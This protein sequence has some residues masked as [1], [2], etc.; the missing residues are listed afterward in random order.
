MQVSGS[1]QTVSAAGIG[2]I[3]SVSWA[4]PENQNKTN[5]DYYN[6]TLI[7]SH[8]NYTVTLDRLTSLQTYLYSFGVSEANYSAVS[9][10]AVD[11]CGQTS[12]SLLNLTSSVE[13]LSTLCT[14]QN[15]QQSEVIGLSAMLAVVVV[16]AT[17][18]AVL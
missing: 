12:E 15:S 14:C 8:T 5:I 10:T 17:F 18:L 2:A 6:I 16:I 1:I 11:V 13:I 7:G 9:V 4:P 3:A